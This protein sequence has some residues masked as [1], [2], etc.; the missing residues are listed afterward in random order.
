MAPEPGRLRR[1]RNIIADAA[2]SLRWI[3]GHE[4]LRLARRIA[5]RGRRAP[6][7]ADGEV[8]V[9]WSGYG[10]IPPAVSRPLD[11]ARRVFP[12]FGPARVRAARVL[13]EL[14][15]PIYLLTT[16]PG[17]EMQVAGGLQRRFAIERARRGGDV[18]DEQGAEFAACPV[19]L[20]VPEE[21]SVAAGQRRH[22]QTRLRTLAADGGAG[23]H[24]LVIDGA[25]DTSAVAQAVPGAV[26]T[27]IGSVVS[28]GPP[29]QPYKDKSYTFVEGQHPKVGAKANEWRRGHA[30]AVVTALAHAAPASKI[31]VIDVFTAGR[32][33]MKISAA[34][35]VPAIEEAHNKVRPH[36]LNL[37]LTITDEPGHERVFERDVLGR[38]LKMLQNVTVIAAT[39]NRRRDAS[40]T[41]MGFPARHESVTAVG[42][43]DYAG[44]PAAYSRYGDKS[45]PDPQ[46][47]WLAPGGTEELPLVTVGRFSY[48]GTSLSTPLVAGLMATYI[49]KTMDREPG[50]A[51]IDVLAS[52]TAGPAGTAPSA[53]GRG[54]LSFEV[55]AESS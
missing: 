20:I 54:I 10:A 40:I 33:E 47:W 34:T 19:P 49:S 24:V 3:A 52:A 7:I 41:P 23:V 48:H 9:R 46:A 1:T 12:G 22:L 11:M 5:V 17:R 14:G 16:P 4:L 15:G 45:G 39:G 38:L 43:C 32:E 51:V 28:A 13:A 2:W 44:Q 30:T 18:E 29:D 36:L 26:A 42:A 25:A 6:G 35:L 37:S 8:I 55:L 27:L 50:V 21:E 31:S 53:W